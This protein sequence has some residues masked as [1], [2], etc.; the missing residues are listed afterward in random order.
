MDRCAWGKG[1]G[2][3]GALAS[4]FPL[5]QKKKKKKKKKMREGERHTPRS[6][7]FA[8]GA[9]CHSKS[10]RLRCGPE[11]CSSVKAIRLQ[12]ES[13]NVGVAC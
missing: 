2:P 9:R 1:F 12:G 7:M 11:P 4:P 8:A 6:F 3:R 5:K 10:R 13:F